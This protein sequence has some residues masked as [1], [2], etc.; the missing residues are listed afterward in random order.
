MDEGL[1]GCAAVWT[2][3]AAKVDVKVQCLEK[4]TGDDG[5]CNVC[6]PG[7]ESKCGKANAEAMVLITSSLT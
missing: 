7:A 5:F 1:C 3:S 2:T 6:R 4:V